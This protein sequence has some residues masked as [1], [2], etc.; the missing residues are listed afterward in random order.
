[1][2]EAKLTV[3]PGSLEYRFA[4]P[5]WRRGEQAA[6]LEQLLAQV[7]GIDAER[8]QRL[9]IAGESPLDHPGFVALANECRAR[10]FRRVALETDAAPLARR[11]M[12]T[13]LGRLG[14]SEIAVVMSGLREAAH[15]AV[16]R[17]PGTLVAALEG[18]QRALGHAA[19]GGPHVYLVV[20][21]LR[22]NAEDVEPLLDW[23]IG[24]PGRL[25]GF[26]LSVPDIDRVR[27]ED[28]HLLLPY[29]I[30]AEIAARLF[31]TCQGRNVEYGFTTKRGLI[32]CGAA[33]LHAHFGTVFFDRVQYLQH[34]PRDA[35]DAGF[36]RIGACAECS[37][38]TSCPGVETAY[39]EQFGSA[40]FSAVPLDVSMNW[41]LR[42]INSLEQ[43][44]YRNISPFQN[45]SPVN[46]RGLIRINGHCNMSCAFCFVDRT[47]PDIDLETLRDEIAK[48][49]RGGTR[50][51]VIS[52]GEP[53]IHPQ[54]PE[55]LR[56]ARSLAVFDVIE[57]QSNGVKCA[58]F[59][60]ARELVD[61]GLNKVTVSLHSID[62]EHSDR[63]TRLPQAFGKTVRAIHNFRRLG[64]LTQ[65]AHV[66]TKSN[67]QE[68][69][70]TVRYLRREFP[71][72]GGHLS[73]CLAIAQGI[74][75]LVF[76]WV[77]PTF[78]EIKPYVSDALDFCLE[79]GIGFGGMIGQ[80]GYPP[81]MLD[82]ELRYYERVLDKVF[83]SED[84]S[85]QFYKPEK[86]RECS[87]DAYCLGPRR[88]YVEHYGD[89]EIRP[90][91]AAISP[92]VG[93]G[94]AAA[95]YSAE[96]ALGAVAQAA[97]APPPLTR[98]PRA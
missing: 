1:V 20:P 95:E 51:L 86:C 87:F 28:R 78:S 55:V 24:L 53:T 25:R 32:P 34:A 7:R 2:N 75:D 39:L 16:L 43:F 73:L 94:A 42:R 64:V 5:G 88:S 27:A 45:E 23:A 72:D 21:L 93:K 83:R 69:P 60:Y 37:L 79:T 77:I 29:S 36:A 48:M 18:L 41:K 19:S 98:A 10:G 9:V 68:L 54:L 30:Q 59:D 52:G 3:F 67:Y 8:C 47:V 57:M 46:P 63:I 13:L 44:E 90:F 80:G 66:I 82:G 76:Q 91:R 49:A 40:E 70:D 22:C 97:A 14:F 71:A 96:A 65:I 62:P 17:E 35:A 74:S 12:A 38:S 33:A 6:P 61:A 58:D 89:A 84:A 81:C 11:G 50:H 85:E 15:D 56:F 92:A 4:A 26:L 31:R